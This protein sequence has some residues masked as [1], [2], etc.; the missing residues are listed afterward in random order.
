MNPFLLEIATRNDI[1]DP[2]VEKLKKLAEMP[3]FE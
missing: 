1:E 3:N 2:N